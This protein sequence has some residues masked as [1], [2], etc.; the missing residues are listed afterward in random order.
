MPNMRAARVRGPRRF[1]IEQ[2]P[3]PEPGPGEV[4]VRVEAC[5]IC[6]SDLHFLHEGLMADGHTPGHE[7]AGSIDLLGANVAGLEVGQRVAIEPIA[8]CGVCDTCQQ[9]RSNICRQAKLL[10]IHQSGGFAEQVVV[11]HRR[12][13]PV[14]EA[15]SPSLAALTEPIAVGVHGLRRGGLETGQ[16]VLVL[17]A[18]SVGLLTC[19]AAK[20]MGA[21]DVWVSARHEHQ[22][23]CAKH[24]GADRVLDE[25]EATPQ[26]LAAL[27]L[28]SDIDLVVETVG[29]RADT[30][31][32]AGAA[33]RPGGTVS[34]LGLFMGA[35]QLEPFPLLLK[36]ATLAWS[37]C[38]EHHAERGA[39][40]AAATAILDA[41]RERLAV[42]EDPSLPLASIDAAFALAADKK[43][44]AL[45]VTVLP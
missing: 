23:E 26:A 6:G 40:F 14:P 35:V 5:G 22:A 4:R 33:I 41:E 9:G 24:F 1:E 43:S 44:G 10:G 32:A 3:L 28:Q 19:L 15:V 16:R 7:M 13:F 20:S 29:G 2:V 18:G 8:G 39:D 30:L 11:D 12:V 36:E 21:G 37:N 17:G 31:L 34:V 45:K 38:Y 27:G 42:M 25:S